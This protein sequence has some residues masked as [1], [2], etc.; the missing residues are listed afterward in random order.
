MLNSLNILV[1]VMP[2]IIPP[3]TIIT[4]LIASTSEMGFLLV[5][6]IKDTVNVSIINTASEYSTLSDS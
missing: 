6:D 3:T 5:S 2:Q 4:M 1:K